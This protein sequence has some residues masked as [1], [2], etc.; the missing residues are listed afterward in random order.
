MVINR[1]SHEEID[2][3]P[4]YPLANKLSGNVVDLCPVG[5]LGDKD[6]LY[7]QR[8][9]FMKKHAGVCTGC[10]TGCSIDGRGEPGHASIASSRARIRT[11]TSGGCA[12]KAATATTTC[13]ATERLIEPRR[14]EGRRACRMSNGRSLPRDRRASLRKAGRP[15]GRRALAAPDGRRSVSAGQVCRGSSIRRRVLALGPVPV[16][17]EDE[18]F[19]NGFTIRAEKCPNRRGV[20]EVVAHFMRRR[21]RTFDD[22]LAELD[23]RTRSRRPGSPAAIKQPWID[24]ADGR[25]TCRASRLLIV[26]DMF[27]SPLWQR[28]TYQLPGAAFAERDGSYVNHRRPAAIVRLGDS[29]AGRRAGRRAVVLATAGRCPA[30][31]TRGSVLDEIAARDSAFRAAAGAV[32]PLGVDLKVNQLAG[33][34][35]ENE[36]MLRSQLICELDESPKLIVALIKIALLIVR[37]DDGGGLSGAAGALDRGLGAGS[38]RAQSR[39]HS[40]DEDQAVRPRPAAGRRAEVHLQGRIHAR[41]RRQGAVIAW[42]RSSILA[43][44]LAD[45]R[46]RFPSAAC[47]RRWAL[48]ACRIRFRLIVAPGLDVGMIYVFALSSIAVYGVILGGWASN[49]KYSFLGGAALQR[50]ADRLRN[51]A[52][53]GHPR[54]RA[55]HAARCGWTRSSASRPTAACGTPSRSRWASSCSSIA[56]FA[57]AAR[58]PFDLPEAE[59][60]LIGGYHTEYSGMKLLLF[61]IAEFLHMITASFLIVILFLGGW[62][63]WGLTGSS[64]D[65]TWPM[66]I[67]RIV[68]L[69]AKVL[70]VILFFMLVRW[71]WPRFRFDQLMTLAWKVMLP[72]GL[73]N[74]VAV[75]VLVEYRHSD[76]STALG[77]QQRVDHHRRRLGRHARRLDRRRHAWRR[78]HTDNRPRPMASL[79]IRPQNQRSIAP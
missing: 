36:I 54:R 72:L 13:T 7:Q 29:P 48:P 4:G 63:F 51:A 26:Q 71:S 35:A 2:V 56:A 22:L 9:W 55:G 77:T 23:G 65:V 17:G 15:L 75:A 70:A 14:R 18:T 16:V 74:L 30:C 12:T 41:P 59:Q 66:A 32:P 61:L 58:L 1:G 28:A 49:N 50:P 76:R 10:S 44:A 79:P 47:C 69:A 40:A 37:P 21:D 68:V 39:R 20:E 60:E 38:P 27:A 52:G 78:L 24:D 8:V 73:V 5:A 67:L 34:A 3:F 43:A 31:T 62:H 45:L 11:S 64:D 46:R 42:R 19:P 6:F 57:E 33:S 25:A 53:P